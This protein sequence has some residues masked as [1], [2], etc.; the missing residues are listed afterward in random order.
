MPLTTT[1]TS[2]TLR[3]AAALFQSLPEARAVAL[4]RGLGSFWYRCVRYRRRVARTGLEHA[5]GSVLGPRDLDRLCRENFAHYGTVLAEFLRLPRL[6]AEQLQE[7]FTVTGL[8][9]ATAA[10][11]RG[12]GLIILTAH[13]G[14]WEYL[15]AAQGAW[16]LD[17]LVITRRAHQKGVDRF[18]Q[19]V[20]RARGTR[21][22]DAY[23]SLGAVMR[24]L[25]TG[26]T[27]G[28]SI[29]QH[30]GG[31]TA[32]RVPFFGVEAGTVKAPAL[33]ALRTAAPVILLLS[34]RDRDGRH[35]AWFSEE[36]P[37]AAGTDTAA[38]VEQTTARY[39]ALLEAFIREH[40]AQWSWVHRRWKPA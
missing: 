12:R 15:A 32:V 4:G 33:L 30:E 6:S 11:A 38:I 23:G 19:E 36:I 27:V 2:A 7:R 14:N 40:P 18:W 9:H 8:E 39:N 29:D 26:G 10:R 37:L 24:H 3:A 5:F 21:F 25:R 13:V 28:M 34:W 16:N 35:H 20:R 17:M 22:V 1:M 31:T